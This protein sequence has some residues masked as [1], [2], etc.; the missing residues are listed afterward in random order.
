LPQKLQTLLLSKQ[1][2]HARNPNFYNFQ[3]YFG[4]QP[5]QYLIFSRKER[6]NRQEKYSFAFFAREKLTIITFT[7]TPEH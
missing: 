5:D 1:S 4:A 7:Y 2:G 3:L 6:K